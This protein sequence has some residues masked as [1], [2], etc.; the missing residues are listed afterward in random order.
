[1]ADGEHS[2]KLIIDKFEI[3][4]PIFQC[5]TCENNSRKIS[6]SIDK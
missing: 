1:L 5:N 4:V 6:T 3:L 2:Q